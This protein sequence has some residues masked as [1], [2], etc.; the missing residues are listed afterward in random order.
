MVCW[1]LPSGSLDFYKFSLVCGYLL[2]SALSR[3]PPATAKRAWGRLPVLPP[4]PTPV[5]LFPNAQ[6]GKTPPR[7]FAICCCWIPQSSIET[8]SWMN[9]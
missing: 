9:A 1:N 2:S 4:I 6:V 5:F 8:L 3:F 7:S